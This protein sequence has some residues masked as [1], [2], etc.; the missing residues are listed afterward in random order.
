MQI[1]GKK[2]CKS[3]HGIRNGE[4]ARE[5]EYVESIMGSQPVA[6][7][8]ANEGASTCVESEICLRQAIVAL[9]K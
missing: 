7:V 6:V 4:S 2:Y 9:R 3:K 5:G 1:Q 8:S